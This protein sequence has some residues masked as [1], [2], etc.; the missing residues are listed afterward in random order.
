MLKPPSQKKV[1][2]LFTNMAYDLYDKFLENV[3][4]IYEQL[5]PFPAEPD[6]LFEQVGNRL[7]VEFGH[8]C[9]SGVKKRRK[10]SDKIKI[11]KKNEASS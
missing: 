9:A 1:D 10:K 2:K 4:I 5:V 6:R 3:G 11:S 7:I 8:V